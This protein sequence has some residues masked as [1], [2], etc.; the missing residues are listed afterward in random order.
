MKLTKLLEGGDRRSIARAEEV[1]KM[2]H[3][4]P[5]LFPELLEAMWSPD[6]I[7]QMRAADATEK[8]T[9]ANPALAVPHKKELL[10]L[11]AE[12]REPGLC[13]HLAATLPRL[14]LRGGERSRAIAL[15]HDYLEMKS[16]IVKTCALQALAEMA[17]ED[18]KLRA[19]VTDILRQAT[20][21][22]TAAMKARS[23]RLLLQIEN[24]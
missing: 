11:A 7:V 13:W 14:T 16:S 18:P 2:V 24:S 20:R 10:G 23:R 3:A 12:A 5:G 4:N 9:R 6:P 17:W 22:G 19:K 15:L 8:I 21:T 1:V